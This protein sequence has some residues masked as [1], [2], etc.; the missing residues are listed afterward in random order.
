MK[1]RVAVR[2][3]ALL[4]P[5]LSSFLSAQPFR[6]ELGLQRVVQGGVALVNSFSGGIDAPVFQLLDIDGDGKKDLFLL[7]KD[8]R[9]VLYRYTSPGSTPTFELTSFHF[10][11]LNVGT[12]FRFVDID[13]DGDFDLFCNGPSGTVNFF[14]N[15][16]SA[17]S[18]AFALELEGVKDING[19]VILSEE[20]SIPAFA[21]LDG[22]GDFDFFSGNSVGS[23]WYY[24]NVGT[25]TE[26][27][28]RFVTDRFQNITIIGL[29]KAA[30]SGDGLRKE[31]QPGGL[32]E[33]SRHGAM[34][35]AFGDVDGDGDQDLVWGDFFNRSLYFLRNTG[36][37]ASPQLVLADSTWPKESPVMTDGFNMPQLADLDHDGRV[38]LL[39]GVLY[40]GFSLNNL[41]YYRNT[42]T[43]QNH[44]FAVETL[45][46]I[47][48]LD[49]GSAS[50]P[51]F[52][53]LNGDGGSDLLIGSEDGKLAMFERSGNG[54]AS[55]FIH[56]TDH[57][58]N[59]SGLF[60]VSPATA[61]LNG[62]GKPDLLVGDANGRLRLYRGTDSSVEDT[63][64][65]LRT[66]SFGQN[67]APAL[68]DIDKNGTLDLF[69]GTGGGRVHFYR[70]TGIATNPVFSRESD[71]FLSIDI[72][73]D[74]KPVFADLD[75]DGD[76]D[77][78]VGGRDGSLSYW[79]NDGTPSAF[80]FVP[81]QDFFDDINAGG[82][83]APAFADI[84]GDGDLDLFL[85]N[86][87]GGLYFYRNDRILLQVTPEAGPGSFTLHQNYPNPFNPVTT[88][89]YTLRGVATVD[90][91]IVDL[92]GRCVRRMELGNQL[93]GEYAVRF[94]AAGLPTGMYHA[95]TR[96]GS[97]VQSMKM[98]LIK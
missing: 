10:Q 12:W 98:L 58:L 91:E 33:I 26:F 62:D 35:I 22:D 23:I 46:L 70:N 40:P 97:S 57:F 73:D 25:R 13:D 15:T 47:H 38:D 93:P 85:G 4:F 44:Q 17:L 63:T 84:D 71:F 41:R 50:S 34:A 90:V 76:L 32:A 43:A 92:L 27:R 30:P 21:D 48:T 88:I 78:I 19:A 29:G 31:N 5:L 49:V 77:L 94:D 52:A 51:F 59:L 37:Q 96:A 74:A 81:I 82:R 56:A 1:F 28:F 36:T 2:F 86:I 67:A 87:K 64:F 75:N 95:R 9:L 45:N 20:I 39:V 89:R 65:A 61:D 18:P 6:Q 7:D 54:G 72:G 83:A 14:R 79:R 24:E 68:V 80:S 53:D 42:G 11:S 8:R 60:N 66:V 16:G 3:F 69:V 55:S